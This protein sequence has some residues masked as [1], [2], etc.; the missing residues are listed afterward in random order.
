MTPFFAH[1]TED[2]QNGVV[3]LL[4]FLNHNMD[5]KTTH[6]VTFLSLSPCN[7]VLVPCNHV[8]VM[9]PSMLGADWEI[10]DFM[11]WEIF[12]FNWENDFMSLSFSWS[13]LPCGTSWRRR[14]KLLL[15]M[16]FTLSRA[17]VLVE[18]VK[19]QQDQTDALSC[20]C[21]PLHL[22]HSV[23]APLWRLSV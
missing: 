6:P 1:L 10:F 9:C 8:H 15:E 13:N 18:E 23:I 22:V 21:E 4:G 12:D 19:L 16:F 2:N 11:S 20:L 17:T 14:G 7:L 5:D 3:R